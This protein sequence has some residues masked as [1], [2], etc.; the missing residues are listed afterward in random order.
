M[1]PWARALDLPCCWRPPA[2]P[3][4]HPM[5]SLW[6]PRQPQVAANR[7]EPTLDRL[8]QRAMDWLEDQTPTGR[9]RDAGVRSKNF[10]LPT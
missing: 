2:C 6:R 1:A 10:W 3:E 9:L 5:E 7:C 4:L 8:A